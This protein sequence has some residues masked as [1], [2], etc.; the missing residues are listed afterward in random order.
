MSGLRLTIR[1]TLLVTLMAG[2]LPAEPARGEWYVGG[3]GGLSVSGSLKD[4]TLP[5][6]GQR[7]AEQRFP[8]AND[9]LDAN[10]RGTLT[11]T[12]KT[13][14]LSLKHS[15]MF[16]GKVGYF[17]SDEKLPWLGI[18]LEAFTTT[19][20]VKSQTV[21]T[22]HDMTYQPNTPA[23]AAQC[24]PPVP[25]P[26]CPGFVLNRSQLKVQESSLRVTTVAFNLVARYPGT[27]L[28]PYIGVGGGALYFSSSN[29]SF[30]GRQ[31]YPG[32]NLMAGSRVLVTEEWGVFAEAKYNL[33]NVTNFDPVFGLS[34]MYSIFHFV[35]GV[36]YH[37]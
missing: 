6:F 2:W 29:G 16:G 37:F 34:G 14:A 36:T 5:V 9:P 12:F 19:P 23:S 27:F 26:N 33:A 3:Y 8:Q 28:Q 24:L 17:F 10:G 18:E 13:S 25:L 15:P 7:L 32:L 4:V 35:G 1:L 22:E 11:Q 31:F 21:G 20:H 30:Q